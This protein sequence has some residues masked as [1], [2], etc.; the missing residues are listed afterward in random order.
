MAVEVYRLYVLLFIRRSA[1]QDPLFIQDNAEDLALAS[2]LGRQNVLESVSFLELL[3]QQ[4]T[5]PASIT[6]LS[7][8]IA[9][10]G[11]LLADQCE[12]EIDTIPAEFLDQIESAGAGL[13]LLQVTL[14]LIGKLESSSPINQSILQLYYASLW[15]LDRI[16]P[17]Y[18]F[19]EPPYEHSKR[20][21]SSVFDDLRGPTASVILDMALNTAL[22]VMELP[23][24]P[25]THLSKEVAARLL[26]RL[27]SVRAIRGVATRSPV[28][29][30]LH[31]L[32][33]RIINNLKDLRSLS[34]P[35]VELFSR[36]LFCLVSEDIAMELLQHIQVR[37]NPIQSIFLK[38]RN[39]LSRN[40][41]V[42]WHS[43]PIAPAT[44][45][46]IYYLMFM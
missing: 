11:A 13:R 24:L 31:F 4:S 29:S 7:T 8:V 26:E 45:N 15:F 42:L 12:G 9:I 3:V 16:C 20:K 6:Q 27:S 39:L 14:N 38:Q 40:R 28:I 10:C 41:P 5:A 18:L 30:K 43:W 25:E 2:Q 23:H 37:S 19:S 35:T 32:F 36:A 21:N 33:Q 22:R 17:V 34:L 1:G 44:T 46:P